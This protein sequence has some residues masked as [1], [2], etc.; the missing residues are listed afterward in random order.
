MIMTNLRA[1]NI[2]SIFQNQKES[3]NCPK[4]LELTHRTRIYDG[5]F[6]A[7]FIDRADAEEVIV[8]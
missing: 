1:N 8:F 5:A 4:T 3:E 6:V 2:F 7:V